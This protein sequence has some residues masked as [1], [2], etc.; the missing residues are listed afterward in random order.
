M[1]FEINPWL[2]GY[3][4]IINLVT[5]SVFA[6]D[7]ISS[8]SNAWRTR[9]ST[10]LFFTLIGGTV[11]ALFSMYLFRHKTRKSSFQMIFVLI[12]LIQVAL[13]FA[14]NTYLANREQTFESDF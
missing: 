8:Q 11:G 13:G 3:L 10:L 6:A 9:E 7:K 14:Y 2:L 4:I 12:I 5:L 1:A